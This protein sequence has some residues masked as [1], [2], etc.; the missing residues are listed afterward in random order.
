MKKILSFS[1]AALTI[2]LLNLLTIKSSHTEEYREKR[3][4]QAR[5][6][7]STVIYEICLFVGDGN[8]CNE[9]G[10]TTRECPLPNN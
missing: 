4:L 1:I 2:L 7:G 6:K 8:I 10:T 3:W 5:C 9:W